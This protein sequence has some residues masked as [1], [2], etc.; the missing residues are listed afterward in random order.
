MPHRTGGRIIL[1]KLTGPR[2]H[3][4]EGVKSLIERNAARQ[5]T[6]KFLNDAIECAELHPEEAAHLKLLIRKIKGDLHP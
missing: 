1:G 3:G 2:S 5:N 4:Y 6:R